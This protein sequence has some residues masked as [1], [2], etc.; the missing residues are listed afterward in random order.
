MLA[1]AKRFRDLLSRGDFN[2]VTLSVAKGERKNFVT[3]LFRNRQR[4]RRVETTAQQNN[5]AFHLL[6]VG[7]RSTEPTLF[8]GSTESRPTERSGKLARTV[9]AIPPRAEKEAVMFASRGW[10]ARTRSSRMRFATASLNPRSL[11]NEAR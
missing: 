1:D 10:Q 3:F 8:A 5:G 6:S 4:R 9:S 7:R 2:L 11:R